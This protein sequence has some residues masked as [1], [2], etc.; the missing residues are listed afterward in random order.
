MA[1]AGAALD[2]AWDFGDPAGSE[3][4]L[5][6]LHAATSGDEALEALTQIA[7]AQGLQ[8]KFD[9]AHRTLDDVA[10]AVADGRGR[11]R[12]RCL[13]ERGRVFRSS[14]APADALTPFHDA[15]SL[16]EAAGDAELAVD[17]V[18]MLAITVG[19]PLEQKAWHERGIAM[20]AASDAERARRWLPSLRNNLGWWLFDA[21][22]HADALEQ[23]ERALVERRASGDAKRTRIAEWAV[24]RTLRE[25]GR[26][27]EALEI[28]LRLRDEWL[29]A[30]AVP[31]DVVNE[32]AACET[33]L[34]E[35]REIP[36]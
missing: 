33:V 16:A 36:S 20:A 2:E 7:R 12:I 23:F 22:R 5:R 21:G 17:A 8:G 18:H 29:A 14:G 35:R 4:R 1:L 6:T 13:L 31:P 28:L 10:S 25:L 26:A 19:D 34:A 15:L 30:G 32:I 27:R 24:A 3:A 9:D 11:A